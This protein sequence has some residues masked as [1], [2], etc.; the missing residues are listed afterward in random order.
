M[1]TLCCDAA[2]SVRNWR[3]AV[4][5]YPLSVVLLGGAGADRRGDGRERIECARTSPAALPSAYCLTACPK[6]KTPREGSSASLRGGSALPGAHCQ[7]SSPAARSA[8]LAR[9]SSS[10]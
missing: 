7:N 6:F 2:A 4:R 3:R 10:G 8:L 5:L 1:E 9:S